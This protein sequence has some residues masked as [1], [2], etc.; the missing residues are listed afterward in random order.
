MLFNTDINKHFNDLL[1]YTCSI[2]LS[3]APRAVTVAGDTV[4]NSAWRT[5]DRWAN[6]RAATSTEESRLGTW[7]WLTTNA[8]P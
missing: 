1:C 4:E 6:A 2:N 8:S 5:F 7:R 3:G